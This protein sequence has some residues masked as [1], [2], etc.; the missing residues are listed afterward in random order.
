MNLNET[1]D[2]LLS[3]SDANGSRTAD[4]NE[5]A[6]EVIAEQKERLASMA[7]ESSP[8]NTSVSL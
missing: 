6:P 8:C 4:T 7:Q 2:G 5:A 1:L 3:E